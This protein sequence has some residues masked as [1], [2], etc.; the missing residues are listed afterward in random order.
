MPLFFLSIFV[1]FASWSLSL[2]LKLQKE[3]NSYIWQ[4]IQRLEW[5]YK[6]NKITSVNAGAIN[7]NVLL[8]NLVLLLPWVSVF[9]WSATHDFCGNE[10]RKKNDTEALSNLTSTK[11]TKRN[12][13]SFS[14]FVNFFFN[15]MERFKVCKYETLV[16]CSI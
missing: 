11:Y 5:Q 9:G 2:H 13:K 10:R 7:T 3:K 12:K 4:I 6:T 1:V 8:Y 15:F 16:L 14:L